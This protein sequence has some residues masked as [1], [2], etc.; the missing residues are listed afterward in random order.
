MVTNAYDMQE[1]SHIVD[2]KQEG[3]TDVAGDMLEVMIIASDMLEVV[4]VLG[5][6]LD[7]VTP[8]EYMY[9][10]LLQVTCWRW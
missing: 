9:E 5:D 1:V 4:N 8:D 3:V 2:D 7:V 6:M 10:T